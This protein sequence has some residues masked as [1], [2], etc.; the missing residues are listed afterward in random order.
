[1]IEEER[2]EHMALGG[3]LLFLLLA[4]QIPGQKQDAITVP[5]DKSR[6]YFELLPLQ[7]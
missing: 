6:F 4:D 5:M 7:P 2:T 1:M 3:I